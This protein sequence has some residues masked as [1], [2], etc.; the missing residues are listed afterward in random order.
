MV[1][2]TQSPP[3]KPVILPHL[4]LSKHTTPGCVSQECCLIPFGTAADS[5]LRPRARDR[6]RPGQ[7]QSSTPSAEPPETATHTMPPLPRRDLRN[8]VRKLGASARPSQ[9]WQAL[10]TLEQLCA[11]DMSPDNLAAI[12]AAG[13]IHP[14]V[15]MLTSGS[16]ADVQSNALTAL[17]HLVAHAGNLVAIAAA[18]AI[19]SLVQL[20][21]PAS[22]LPVRQNASSLLIE[23]SANADCQVAIAAAG[24]I[25]QLVQLLAPDSLPTLSATFL[26]MRLAPTA[27]NADVIVA[28]GAI[29]QLVQLLRSGS[30]AKENAAGVLGSLALTAEHA[31]TIPPLVQLMGPGSSSGVRHNA[32]GALWFLAKNAANKVTIAAGAIPPL[33]QLLGSGFSSATR[34]IAAETLRCLAEN[35]EN[36]A[37][38]VAAAASVNMV[39]E[40]GRLRIIEFQAAPSPM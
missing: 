25:P 36:V 31:V 5:L 20:L 14:L 34:N 3:L 8:L 32:A 37:A 11:G 7:R 9:Q 16:Q 15:Q 1:G 30:P 19:P 35:P 38:I 10:F 4:L 28:A 39:R 23:L 40:M 33:L 21:G 24:A 12:A 13:A 18:G 27:A 2:P 17:V 26:L 6:R 29:P 22:T